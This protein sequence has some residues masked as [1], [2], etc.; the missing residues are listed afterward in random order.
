MSDDDSR[1]L[2]AQRMAQAHAAL[3]EGRL[4]QQSGETTLGVVNRAYYAMFYAVLALLQ[5]KGLTPRKHSGAIALFDKEFVK[6]G[7]LPPACPKQLHAAFNLRQLSD[8]Q[9]LETVDATRAADLV[10]D[11]ADSVAAV[12]GTLQF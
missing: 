10:A 5:T 7:I 3:D 6:A 8:Y 12:E 2:A 1:V 11:A 9:P 4:L